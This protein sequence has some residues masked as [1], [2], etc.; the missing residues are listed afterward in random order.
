MERLS[1]EPGR[2]HDFDC[3]VPVETSWLLE[4]LK[5]SL[6]NGLARRTRGGTVEREKARRIN[7]G[8]EIEHISV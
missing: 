4:G 7:A 6:L 3:D 5:G 1:Y 8:F 2:E